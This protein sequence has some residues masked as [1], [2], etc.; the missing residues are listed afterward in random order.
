MPPTRPHREALAAWRDALAKTPVAERRKGEWTV[1]VQ[2]SDLPRWHDL[3]VA[4]GGEIAYEICSELI[5]G[6]LRIHA[7]FFVFDAP[8][9][10]SAASVVAALDAPGAVQHAVAEVPLL[11][12]TPPEGEGEQGLQ[13]E[14][15]DWLALV[16]PP[17]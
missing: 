17:A 14:A 11:A 4:L 6:E 15:E 3:A 2:Q 8:G 13:F 12:D 9:W 7:S 5:S 16:V 10:P 1:T